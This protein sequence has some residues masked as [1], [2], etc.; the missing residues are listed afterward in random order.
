MEG[1]DVHEQP[2]LAI[3]TVASLFFFFSACIE[4]S[5][6]KGSAGFVCGCVQTV[7]QHA[8]SQQSAH[9]PSC[10]ASLVGPVLLKTHDLVN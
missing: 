1:V 7:S 6:V 2:L 5:K 9:L 4:L 10:F 3:V 8:Y